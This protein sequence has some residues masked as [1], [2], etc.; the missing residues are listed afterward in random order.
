ML[1]GNPSKQPREVSHQEDWT[2]DQQDRIPV[3]FPS[4][5]PVFPIAGLVG[6]HTRRGALAKTPGQM[7]Y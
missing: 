4:G 7:S 2:G 1:G 5:R 3:F 6:T